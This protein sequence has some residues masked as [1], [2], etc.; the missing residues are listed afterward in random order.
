[1]VSKTRNQ[2]Q[3]PIRRASN[4]HSWAPAAFYAVSLAMLILGTI[5]PSGRIWGINLLAHFPLGWQ[6]GILA[7][8][9]VALPIVYRMT[10]A[11][12]SNEH[13]SKGHG[14]LIASIIIV[15]ISA[16]SF[17][18]LRNETHFLGDGYQLLARL[19][20]H[21][22]TVKSWEAVVSS[23]NRALFS[24]FGGNT[25]DEALLAFQIVSYVAGLISLLGTVVASRFLFNDSV[26]RIL[27]ALGMISGGYTLLFFGYVENYPL[28]VT[29]ALLALLTGLL[30]SKGRISRW[31]V[32][33][34]TIAATLFHIFGI[35]LIPGVLYL[36]MYD[37]PAGRKLQALSAKIKVV[38]ALTVCAI[39]VAIYSYLWST[40]YFFRFSVLPFA[41]DQFTVEGETLLAPKRIADLINFILLLLPGFPLL[42]AT[43]LLFSSRAGKSDPAVKYLI[44]SALSALGVTFLFNPKLGLPRDWDLFSFSVLPLSALAYYFILAHTPAQA[45]RHR[46]VT[47]S[48]VLGFMILGSRVAAHRMPDVALTQLREYLALD[49]VKSR[50][51]RVLM[52]SYFEDQK[53]MPMAIKENND[54]EAAYPEMEMNRKITEHVRAHQYSEGAALCRQAL[55]L[56]PQY[57]D[58][59]A[60]LG[61]CYM[62]I[63]KLD[64]GAVFLEIANGLNPNSPLV[65]SSLATAY[66]RQNKYDQAE[67]LLRRALAIDSLCVN[68]LVNMAVGSLSQGKPDQSLHYLRKVAAATGKEPRRIFREA[69][70]VFLESGFT[71]QAKEAYL[72]ALDRGTDTAYVRQQLQKCG[73]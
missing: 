10:T 32:V 25:R 21:A 16:C 1:M 67:R 11:E 6:I 54:A 13:E 48:A 31:W 24:A 34:P 7:V 56:N 70:D 20:D 5:W 69:G 2:L 61:T 40:D 46:A 37:S 57:P 22:P 33:P 8:G 63:G 62:G 17:V 39:L 47:L 26:G 23:I 42:T 15:V 9:L 51:G 64:S 3:T 30:G 27:F 38:T 59:Y 4:T 68:A 53:N 45:L 43:A 50:T 60:N 29:L 44:V 41:T 66:Q 71:A 49:K 12:Y 52:I 73:L 18:L 35:A 72:I 19:A 36:V 58:V 65:M 28:F 14:D 55:A